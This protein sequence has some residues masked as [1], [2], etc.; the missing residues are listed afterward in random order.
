MLRPQPLLLELHP[1]ALLDQGSSVEAVVE[2]LRSAGYVGLTIDYSASTNRR[3]AYG[4]IRDIQSL[5]TPFD[6][7][8]GLDAWPHQLWLEPESARAWLTFSS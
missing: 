2:I 8:D 4:R 7:A 6:P 5:L 3:A 1:N